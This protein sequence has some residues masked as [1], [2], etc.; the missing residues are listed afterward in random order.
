MLLFIKQS[1]PSPSSL[2][3]FRVHCYV[4]HLYRYNYYWVLVSLEASIIR[5]R[6]LG[7]FLG[8]ILTHVLGYLS[9]IGLL[10]DG[11]LR[12]LFSVH[13][14]SIHTTVMPTQVSLL[15]DRMFRTACLN[16]VHLQQ[17]DNMYTD[18]RFHITDRDTDTV[19]YD[20]SVLHFEHLFLIRQ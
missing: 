16:S 12:Q 14:C 20:R 9:D 15:Q 1:L 5:C 8:I 19:I 4:I 18:F 13:G 7:A 17:S 3:T 10:S 11:D 2:G 6:I